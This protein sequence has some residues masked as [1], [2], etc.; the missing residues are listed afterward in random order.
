MPR[1]TFESVDDYLAAQPAAT[2]AALER[3]RA[4][5]RKA[6]PSATEGISYQIPVYKLN[7]AMVLY[8]AGYERHYAVYPATPRLIRELEGELEGLLHNKATIR[9]P[10][11]GSVPAR[12]IAR[13][14]KL[15]AAEATELMLAKAAS[16]KAKSG[17]GKHKKAAQRRAK[18]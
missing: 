16:K 6:L 1:P 10:L 9:F 3:V 15:R 11:P 2:R 18:K 17:A 14:A 4:T 12:L 8:F 7:G 13:I 5:I